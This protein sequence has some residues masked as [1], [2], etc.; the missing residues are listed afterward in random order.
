MQ[1]ATPIS[2]VVT[3]ALWLPARRGAQ[4]DRRTERT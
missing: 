4:V 1:A 3:D 2:G